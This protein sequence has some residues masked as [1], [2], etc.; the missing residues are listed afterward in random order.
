LRV[1]RADDDDH[2]VD[3][4]PRFSNATLDR[5]LC[6]YHRGGKQN[7]V[8]FNMDEYVGLDPSHPQ[9]YRSFMHENCQSRV[10]DQ[11]YGVKHCMEADIHGDVPFVLCS[12]SAR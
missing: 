3:I 5:E 9:S 6:R 7:V 12:L 1:D 10:V 8:T 11:G 4:A 2:D